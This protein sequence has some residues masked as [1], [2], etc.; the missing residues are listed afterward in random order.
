MRPTKRID[1]HTSH[2]FSFLNFRCFRN[3]I[4]EVLSHVDWSTITSLGSLRNHLQQLSNARSMASVNE[5]IVKLVQLWKDDFLIVADRNAGGVWF[6]RNLRLV[7]TSIEP[8]KTT[9]LRHFNGLSSTNSVFDIVSSG[10]NP[11]AEETYENLD[12]S[13]DN[14]DTDVEAATM[15]AALV[16]EEIDVKLP[17]RIRWRITKVWLLIRNWEFVFLV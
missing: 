14:Y 12:Q 15:E 4:F 7:Y 3:D 10:V 2:C 9:L 5:H 17:L 11:Q 6:M 1:I 13:A 8:I 16:E